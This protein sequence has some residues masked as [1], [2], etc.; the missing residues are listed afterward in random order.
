M[1]QIII[2]I[3]T[4][5]LPMALAAQNTKIDP[6]HDY[7]NPH[8]DIGNT[9]YIDWN[10]IL[11]DYWPVSTITFKVGQLS[12]KGKIENMKPPLSVGEVTKL[13]RD[14]MNDLNMSD[15][16]LGNI[17]NDL[18][19]FQDISAAQWQQIGAEALDIALRSGVNPLGGEYAIAADA[20]SAVRAGLNGQ[21]VETAIM[22]GRADVCDYL[23]GNG[24]DAVVNMALNA[25][26]DLGGDVMSE[27]L[28][29]IMMMVA[30][31][32]LGWDLGELMNKYHIWDRED[33]VNKMMQRQMVK[34]LFYKTVSQKLRKR[35]DDYYKDGKW[36][37]KV[38][39]DV[40]RENPSIFRCAIGQTWTMN[41]DLQ[42][43]DGSKTSRYGTYKGH[44]KLVA[45]QT[46]L[47]VFDTNFKDMVMLSPKLPMRLLEPLTIVHDIKNAPTVLGDKKLE[48][49]DFQLTVEKGSLDKSH[50]PFIRNLKEDE[51]EFKVNHTGEFNLQY[52][53]YNDAVY[54]EG[55]LHAEVSY[56]FDYYGQPRGIKGRNL[57]IYISTQKKTDYADVWTPVHHLHVDL[58]FTMKDFVD[59]NDIC[60]LEDDKIFA[61][62]KL[63]SGY[64]VTAEGDPYAKQR[65]GSPNSQPYVSSLTPT[66]GKT[67]S[68]AVNNGPLKATSETSE[69]ANMIQTGDDGI[70]SYDWKSKLD[71][72]LVE[73]VERGESV[74]ASGKLP[75]E[76]A[77]LL[78]EGLRKDDDMVLVKDDA[79]M[80]SIKARDGITFQKLTSRV[81]SKG[82]KGEGTIDGTLFIGSNDQKKECTIS[83]SPKTNY[84]VI[85]FA[86]VQ[87]SESEQTASKIERL[88]K[89]MEEISKEM[90]AHPE[91]AVEL[92]EEMLDISI[93]LQEESLKMQ[94]K[95]LEQ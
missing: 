28:G 78:P 24:R 67:K 95:M 11:D 71:P 46:E 7:T 91:K 1:K 87:V 10:R 21:D 19:V 44:M 94:E 23:V 72:E 93:E 43:I 66:L 75:S 68:K 12:F 18:A 86:D 38:N 74:V 60:I 69:T 90:Q 40:I 2:S 22:T 89:R 70:W 47:D 84:Y 53:K 33:W 92:Q 15:G 55:P 25:G 76:F 64:V 5:M 8:R 49:Y 30:A 54:D 73:M 61:P 35:L 27:A 77:Y 57:A 29:P 80:V 85:Q 59:G 9:S 16:M 83:Y 3:L 58:T 48:S 81:M 88:T 17:D 20:V 51:A 34:E 63:E 41:A 36:L 65:A 62:L 56:K 52:G 13:V 82:F 39:A 32:Q 4:F 79:F 45:H 42:K 26:A 37:I 50:W 6:N 14:V 31:A